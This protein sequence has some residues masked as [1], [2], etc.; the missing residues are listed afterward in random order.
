M[1]K[2]SS[3]Q[4]F[5]LLELLIVIVIISILLITGFYTLQNYLKTTAV[6]E[7]E[8]L[9][10]RDMNSVRSTTYK[11]NKPSKVVIENNGKAYSLW[12]GATKKLERNLANGI[13][14]SFTTPNGKHLNEIRYKPPY[15]EVNIINTAIE[16]K[17][18]SISKNLLVLG[19]TGKLVKK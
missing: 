1:L 16:I 9:F 15:A 2:N 6:R 8:S 3:N 18:D 14:I 5:T 17:N 10:I 7:A 19:V 4:G 13:K 11:R 12:Y